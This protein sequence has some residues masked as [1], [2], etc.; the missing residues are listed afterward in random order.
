[1]IIMGLTILF[2]ALSACKTEVVVRPYALEGFAHYQPQEN[3]EILYR[4]VSP[5]G[6]SVRLS[7]KE[8][9]PAEADKDFWVQA[10]RRYVPDKGYRLM[11]EGGTQKGRY[12]VFLVA[13]T[14][15]DYFYFL[16]FFVQDKSLFVTEA[17]GQYAFLQDY[18]DRLIRF[19]NEVEVKEPVSEKQP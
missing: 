6:V 1:M 13:G 19:V 14:R 9:S 7:L 10:I 17:G 12:F 2:F 11:S 15:Y 18:Q 4:A 5:E 3:S 16:H 8:N